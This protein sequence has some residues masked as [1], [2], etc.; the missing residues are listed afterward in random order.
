MP[1]PGLDKNTIVVYATDNGDEQY[2]WPEG[3]TSPFRGE[4]GTTWEGG[5]RVPC[6]IRWPGAPGGRVSA[7]IST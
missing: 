5:V 3:D 2:M 7:E 4:K 6:L 1:R